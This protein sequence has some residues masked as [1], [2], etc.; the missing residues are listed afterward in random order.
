MNRDE[1][2]SLLRRFKEMNRDK[3]N[4][5][6][7]GLFGSVARENMGEKSDI[8]IVVQLKTQDLFDLIG[9]KLDLEEELHQRV[10]IVS[11]REKM[12]EFLKR[13]IDKEA[14]YV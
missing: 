14:V 9:I 11:Y 7:I 5:I 6:R 13:R 2:I 1:I 3:Y 8:D 12:N 10:D 4:I